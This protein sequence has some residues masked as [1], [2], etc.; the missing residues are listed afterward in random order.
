MSLVASARF[1]SGLVSRR[2]MAVI[3]AD[4]YGHGIERVAEMLNDVD[5][6]AVARVARTKLEFSNT[7]SMSSAT[8]AA[9]RRRST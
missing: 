8:S 4:A 1:A 2:V 9:V 7:F 5:S 6:L 3:K